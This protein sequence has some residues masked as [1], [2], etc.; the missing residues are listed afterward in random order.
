MKQFFEQDIDRIF[1]ALISLEKD[2]YLHDNTLRGW[3]REV[4]IDLETLELDISGELSQNSYKQYRDTDMV[5]LCDVEFKNFFDCFPDV[6]DFDED[7]IN[8]SL[9][10]RHLWDFVEDSLRFYQLSLD[11]VQPPIYDNY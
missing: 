6:R 11:D 9:N 3:H 5:R 2:S 10:E 8:E 1:D 7:A 4:W